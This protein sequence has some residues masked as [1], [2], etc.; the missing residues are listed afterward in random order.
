[1]IYVSQICPCLKLSRFVLIE[2][3]S[4]DP[5]LPSESPRVFPNNHMVLPKRF[6]TVRKLLLSHGSPKRDWDLDT[7]ILSDRKRARCLLSATGCSLTY[8]RRSAACCRSSSRCRIR[9]NGNRNTNTL[10]LI[11]DRFAGL[12]RSTDR[13]TDRQTCRRSISA[14]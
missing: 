12:A 8:D 2:E 7:Q 3:K 14:K 10:F 5:V 4:V 9:C 11:E 6:H 1:M 13:T